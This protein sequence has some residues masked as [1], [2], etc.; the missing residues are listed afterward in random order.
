MGGPSLNAGP[1]ALPPG[2]PFLLDTHVW[3]WYLLGSDRLPRSLAAAI[4]DAAGAIWLSPIS[5]WE[6]CMLHERGRLTFEG[7]P[8]RWIEAALR[9]FP[10]EEAAL[11]GQV[12]IRSHEVD[13]GHRDPAD[14]L[15]AA[16]ALVH[17]LTLVTLDER[18]MAAPW[19]TTRSN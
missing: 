5:V 6:A 1:S 10:V 3:L 4:D 18:L 2:P 9:A 19:L 15:L 7:G 8:R 17:G 14:H 12:A 11:T 13:L 16:S